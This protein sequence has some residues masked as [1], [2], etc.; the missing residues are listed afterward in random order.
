MGLPINFD[1]SQE[2]PRG[3]GD[4][5][6]NKNTYVQGPYYN[7]IIDEDSGIE[8]TS[9][10][11]LRVGGSPE[12]GPIKAIYPGPG[13]ALSGVSYAPTIS[14]T[15]VIEIC[16]G[17]GLTVSCVN[18]V[19]TLC[20]STT[21][22]SATPAI[23]GTVYGLTQVAGGRNTALGH[24]SL[25]NV[26]TGF[27]NIAVGFAA[28]SFL[29]TASNNVVIGNY[30]GD[31]AQNSS[32]YIADGAGALRLH[33]NGFGALSA[34]DFNTGTAGQFLVSN[35]PTS[36]F[37]WSNLPSASET[38]QGIVEIA[39]TAETIAGASNTLAVSTSGAAAVYLPKGCFQTKGDILGGT[40]ICASTRLPVGAT[41]QYLGVNAASATGLEWKSFAIASE[42]QQ[43]IVELATTAETELGTDTTRAVTPAAAKATFISCSIVNSK[44]DLISATGDNIP[45]PL[46]VGA[47]NTYLRANSGTATGLQWT[48]LPVASETVQG[49]TEYATPAETQT[50][51]STALALTP[52][53]GTCTFVKKSDFTAKGQILASTGSCTYS[54]LGATADGQYLVSCNACTTGMVWYTPPTPPTIVGVFPSAQVI[55]L[56]DISICFRRGSGNTC[57]YYRYNPPAPSVCAT[58]AGYY[59]A[60]SNVNGWS[61][62]NFY[63]VGNNFCYLYLT[64]GAPRRTAAISIYYCVPTVQT[65]CLFWMPIDYGTNNA[66]SQNYICLSR[67]YAQ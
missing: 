20:A 19:Y 7:P 51:T 58:F 38:V 27:N 53:G 41:G 62:F 4:W 25:G 42:T 10:G 66:T 49:I 23:E 56:C 14:N 61:P 29:T 22:S 33:I 54:A 12:D 67:V 8:V 1:P 21:I 63:E 26:T 37:S 15:G 44:G 34:N 57:V 24:N 2:P 9:E 35:G 60:G 36:A 46:T 28:G 52:L 30:P 39:T 17:T 65:Y 18:G 3:S 31:N 64:D 40:G 13:I 11:Y 55:T 45:S 5:R 6:D 50:G 59:T 16:A 48:A 32:V 43:G 47:D